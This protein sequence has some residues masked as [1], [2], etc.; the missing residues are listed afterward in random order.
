[1]NHALDSFATTVSPSAPKTWRHAHP[2]RHGGALTRHRRHDVPFEGARC[3]GRDVV[4]CLPGIRHRQVPVGAPRRRG[5]DVVACLL[6]VLRLRVPLGEQREW[7]PVPNGTQGRAF[8]GLSFSCPTRGLGV[9]GAAVAPTGR[10]GCAHPTFGAVTPPHSSKPGGRQGLVARP[11]GGWRRDAPFG[12]LG[13][14]GRDVVV[15]LLDV[16]RRQVPFGVPGRRRRDV[17]ARR[18]DVLRPNVPRVLAAGT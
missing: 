12:A 16:C 1:M 6:D 18:L 9:R 4:A 2:T 13:C 15:C 10:G 8:S 17:V 7:P 11:L 5:R 14:G 3:G